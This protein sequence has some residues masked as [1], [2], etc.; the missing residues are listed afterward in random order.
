MRGQEL[1]EFA[2]VIPVLALFVFGVLDVGRVFHVLIAISNAAREGARYGVS[3]GI[4][5]GVDNTYS[6][7]E[8]V[9]DGAAVLEASNIG[10]QLTNAQVTPTC[11][12]DNDPD[13]D[14]CASGGRLRVVVNYNF[15][16]FL[17]MVFPSTGLDLVRDMEM[18][19]P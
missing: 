1:V 5:R 9:I 3:Y 15:R 7:D 14:T 18:V 4:I 17:L 16:P 19:I 13:A 8:S 12:D 10:L 6:M 11:Q 2:L